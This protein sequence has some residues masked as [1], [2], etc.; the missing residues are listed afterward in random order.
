MKKLCLFLLAC[1]LAGCAALLAYAKVVQNRAGGVLQGIYA[2]KVGRSSAQDVER[3]ASVLGTQV[4]SRR[5][6]NDRCY[7]NFYADNQ[8]L[9]KAHLEPFAFLGLP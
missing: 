4:S 3:L 1:I 6:D 9:A 5:C 8:W 2:L 7:F